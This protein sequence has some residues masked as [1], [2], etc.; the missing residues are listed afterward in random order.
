[1]RR[2]AFIRAS[3]GAAFAWSFGVRA[4]QTERMHHIG[5]LGAT[6]RAEYA[7]FV[8]AM[9]DGL[10]GLGYV[11]GKNISIHYRWA[12]GKY[13][14]L[15]ELA[16]ELVRLKVDVILT[17]GGPGTR[18]AKDATATIP[19][20]GIVVGDLVST[21]LVPSLARPGGN[22]TGQ[23]FFY[24]E[25][26]AK[27]LELIKEAVPGAARVA[28]LVNPANE[29]RHVALAA[30]Y[31]TAQALR[32]ALL[33]IG[34]T[35]R[36]DLAVAFATM[37]E[38]GVHALVVID[39]ALLISNADYIAE[40]AQENSDA[41]DQ[42]QL[43]YEARR[44]FDL[45]CGPSQSL[46]QLCRTRRPDFAGRKTWGS[47]NPA[48]DE[49]R[50]D[51]QFEERPG[52]RSHRASRAPRPR[53]RGDRMRRRRPRLLV[54]QAVAERFG[55]AAHHVKIGVGSRREIGDFFVDPAASL[56]MVMMTNTAVAGAG[57]PL[58]RGGQ[59]RDLRRAVT[60]RK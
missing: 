12:E 50:P 59:A 55:E 1:M 28:V 48:G 37:A 27:R 20:V 22:L 58:P 15:P 44:V 41:N 11:D 33:P 42:R 23:T 34:A 31:Q 18:A 57:G 3:V 53:R 46:V 47:A 19:I 29:A 38:K 6:S 5:L 49:V 8:E 21:G 52:A 30:M 36:E 10:R 60:P 2:R 26:N 9:Q 17:H 54:A 25:I 13:D 40:L 24:T 45:W 39:D 43:R 35:T 56:T 4:E 32:L 7:N 51:H 14:R 16:A